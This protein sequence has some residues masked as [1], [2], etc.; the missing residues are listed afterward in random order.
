MIS[1]VGSRRCCCLLRIAVCLG[2]QQRIISMCSEEWR[3]MKR[4]CAAAG[5]RAVYDSVPN[6]RTSCWFWSFLCLCCCIVA[7]WGTALLTAYSSNS[8]LNSQNAC[9]AAL[10]FQCSQAARVSTRT[11]EK[12]LQCTS[13]WTT[14][15][16]QHINSHSWLCMMHILH[17]A[18][19]H[20]SNAS[21]LSRL[22][23]H[24]QREEG[25]IFVVIQQKQ[26]CH[27]C[28]NLTFLKAVNRWGVWNDGGVLTQT[29]GAASR[30]VVFKVKHKICSFKAPSHLCGCTS[31]VFQPFQ[32]SKVPLFN[33]N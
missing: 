16:C 30:A 7:L 21:L 12:N 27:S 15:V 11:Q 13:A 17:A 18:A 33:R 24:V 9:G 8:R 1:K 10:I 2:W 19:E 6:M 26:K 32:L 28:R 14:L 4:P 29:T 31:A 20:H 3:A 23:L 25:V 22:P 5:V